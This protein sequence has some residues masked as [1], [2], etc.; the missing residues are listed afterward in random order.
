MT[1]HL[2][3]VGLMGAGKT[4]VGQECA[5]RLDR[6]FV[7]TDVEIERTAGHTVAEIFATEGE[8]RFRAR[9]RDAVVEVCTRTEPLVVACGGGVILDPANREALR[10]AG[11][12]VW[13]RAP[14]VEL[15]A[16]VGAG[17]TRPLL[18]DDP[19]GSLARLEREREPAYAAAAQVVVDTAGLAPTTV[20]ERVLSAFA[21]SEVRS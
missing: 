15:A 20:T 16:R 10:A 19:V 7:D 3:L 17:E 8:E 11:T 2:V 14:A 13:L 9:E 18:A 4:T 6:P 5:R 21:A 1:G 12:V